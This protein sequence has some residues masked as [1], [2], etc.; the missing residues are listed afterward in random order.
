LFQ[1]KNGG[2][3]PRA[4]GRIVQL[5]QRFGESRRTLNEMLA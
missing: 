1:A 2:G 4:E 3:E 5:E